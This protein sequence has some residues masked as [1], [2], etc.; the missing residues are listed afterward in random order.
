MTDKDKLRERCSWTDPGDI[1]IEGE[2]DDIDRVMDI[3]NR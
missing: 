2:E 3:L 1:E